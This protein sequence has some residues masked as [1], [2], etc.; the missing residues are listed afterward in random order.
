VEALSRLGIR[1]AVTGGA[2]AQ[3]LTGH[4]RGDTTVVHIER[5]APELVRELRLGPG[6]EGSLT[7][8]LTPGPVVFD[9]APK[10][11]VAPAPLVYAELLHG[12]GE[13]AREAAEIVRER[14]LP[15]F[16]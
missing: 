2:A 12:G 16:T 14:Y 4:Y 15:K 9:A 10:P 3:Q 13:R 1:W 6:P 5:P 8:L 11:G 7:V